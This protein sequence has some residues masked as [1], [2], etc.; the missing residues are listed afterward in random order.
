[1]SWAAL[2]SLVSDLGS[3]IGMSYLNS[4]QALHRQHDAQDYSREMFQNRYQ[5]QVAD[6]KSAG[7][8]PMLAYTSG[9]PSAPSSSAASAQG[10]QYR[11]SQSYNETRIASAQEANI[12]QQTQNLAATK[13]NTEADTENKLLEQNLIQAKYIV[14]T[15]T[16][17][18]IHTYT[19]SLYVA[20]QETYKKIQL[21]SEQISKTKADTGL[22]NQLSMLNRELTELRSKEKA[23]IMAQTGKVGLESQILEPKA[24]A[25]QLPTAY[26]GHV[27][28]DVGKIGTAMWQFKPKLYGGTGPNDY[29]KRR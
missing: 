18:Q 3:Q 21:L 5:M 24:F 4:S 22:T 9:A 2:G 29:F 1:M 17:E 11:P 25:S 19:N 20:M 7:L 8:N 27:A 26:A 12:T 15:K 14:E 13:Q 6:L 10:S 28:H 16:A 23:L